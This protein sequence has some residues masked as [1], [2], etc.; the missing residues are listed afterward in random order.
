MASG[1]FNRA[2]LHKTGS[3][4]RASAKCHYLLREQCYGP[5]VEKVQYLG[6]TLEHTVRDDLVHA[7]THTLPPWAQ[8]AAA[9]FSLAEHFER[10]NGVILTEWKFDLPRD[11]DRATQLAIARDVAVTQLGTNHVYAFAIHEPRGLDQ[12]PHPHCHLI[13]S[14]RELDHHERT[15]EHFFHRYNATHPE[16][17]GARKTPE[18]NTFG[19]AKVERQVYTDIM[20]VHCERAGLAIRYHPDSL[21]AR[22][23]ALT[24][25]PKLFP[26]DSHTY[27]SR[28]IV[29]DRMQTLL[30][31]RTAMAPHKSTEQAD[32]QRYW[33]QRK[34]QLGIT[35][36]TPHA[37]ALARIAEARTLALTTPPRQRRPVA[38]E[39]EAQAITQHL[40]ALE[41]YHGQVV[42][43][44]ALEQAYRPS[45]ARSR[46]AQRRSMTR[47]SSRGRRTGSLGRRSPPRVCWR[48]APR[49]GNGRPAGNGSR[50]AWSPPPGRSC[51]GWISA[52]NPPARGSR[53]G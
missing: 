30:D 2:V 20:N 22:G 41:H 27:H 8:S 16:R 51:R 6:E 29:T 17:G 45:A 28:G 42:G 32:A 24:P 33:E 40:T 49:R 14:A 48:I 3:T 39:H 50:P 44:Q 23:L 5:A 26:S 34:A 1:H 38:L 46:N 4:P 47:C 36:R 7:E 11:T 25:E 18:L 15:P 10:A 21:E 52:M 43:A 35:E 12:Q 53:S 9:Y 31:H 19:A 13:W 37:L